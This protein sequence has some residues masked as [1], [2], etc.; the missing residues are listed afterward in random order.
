MNQ[1]ILSETLYAGYELGLCKKQIIK[2][3]E[4]LM[5]Q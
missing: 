1:G 4:I 5:N 2:F 3:I